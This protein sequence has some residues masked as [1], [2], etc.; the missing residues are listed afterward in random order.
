MRLVWVVIPL[1]LIGIIGIQESF[2]TSPAPVPSIIN[3]HMEL[4][5]IPNLEEYANVTMTY[6]LT[7][8]Q[9]LLDE[10]YSNDSEFPV[11]A[12]IGFEKE[13]IIMKNKL[14]NITFSREIHQIDYVN[15]AGIVTKDQNFA[16]NVPIKAIKEGETSIYFS[17][18]IREH[19]RTVDLEIQKNTSHVKVPTEF[20]GVFT[21]E[22]DSPYRISYISDGDKILS[23]MT[24]KKQLESINSPMDIICKEG[25]RLIFKQ[26]DSP[27]C[28]TPQTAEKLIERGWANNFFSNPILIDTLWCVKEFDKAVELYDNGWK[29]CEIMQIP[30]GLCDPIPLDIHLAGQEYS[31][32]RDKCV[33]VVDEWKDST[34]Y[35]DWLGLLNSKR[36]N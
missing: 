32:F 14:E 12:S 7:K 8:N 3:I 31:E 22:Y 4:T 13:I 9:N 27:A 6:E 29:Q 24:P 18:K 25:L 20:S 10:W 26:D 36:L 2:A 21:N 15:D 11:L 34:N 1:V 16:L 17:K 33:D 28:V 5:N 19:F 23:N 35:P 30:R